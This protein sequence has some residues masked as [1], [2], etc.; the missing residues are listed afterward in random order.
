[1]RANEGVVGA[2]AT[3]AVVGAFVVSLFGLLD[4]AH[5][6]EKGRVLSWVSAG[7]IPTGGPD[8]NF[9]LRFDPLSAVMCLVVTGWAR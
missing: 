7:W 5:L 1:M 3:L 6:P 9:G 2:I 8:I 4:L